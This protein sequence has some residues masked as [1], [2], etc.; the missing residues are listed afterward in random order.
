MKGFFLPGNPE[1]IAALL[2]AE[3]AHRDEERHGQPGGQAQHVA[4]LRP[5]ARPVDGHVAQGVG[6]VAQG[7]EVGY[8]PQGPGHGVPREEH[9]REKHHG[10][11]DG[12][13]HRCGHI[14][15]AC[16]PRNREPHA[17]EHPTAQQRQQQHDAQ[18]AL[19]VNVEGQ[20]G[21]SHQHQGLKDGHQQARED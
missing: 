14:L 6:Q 16:P 3:Q 15:G 2:P 7:E 12:V 4:P 1:A 9:P 11:G 20:H 21:Q 18:V 19:K 8:R 17:D 10:Q 5:Q 13:G